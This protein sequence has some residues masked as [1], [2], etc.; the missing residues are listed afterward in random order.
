MLSNCSAAARVS[1]PARRENAA[2]ADNHQQRGRGATGNPANSYA[3]HH[4]EA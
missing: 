3:E 4:R 1:S 2:M